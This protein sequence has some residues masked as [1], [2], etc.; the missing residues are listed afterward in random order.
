MLIYARLYGVFMLTRVMEPS[1]VFGQLILGLF[2]GLGVHR[3]A[4]RRRPNLK[5]ET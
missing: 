4:V 2:L 3:D 5:T 1:N